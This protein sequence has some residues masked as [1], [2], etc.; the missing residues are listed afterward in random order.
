MRIVALLLVFAAFPALRA[1]AQPVV[2]STDLLNVIRCE[3][4]SERGALRILQDP[5]VDTLISRYVEA[6]RLAGGVQGYRILIYRRGHPTA[7]QEADNTVLQFHDKLPEVPLYLDFESPDYYVIRVGDYRTMIEAAKKLP[8][9]RRH[10]PNAYI[11]SS[12]IKINSEQS[13]QID[14]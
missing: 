13:Q 10:F 5:R 9:I 8:E 3:E 14:E 4:G 2:S 7:R 1:F 11:V 6:N 12:V